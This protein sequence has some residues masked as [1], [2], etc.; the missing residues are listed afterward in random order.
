MPAARL[1]SNLR[2][3]FARSA[4]S[5]AQKTKTTMLPRAHAGLLWKGCIGLEKRD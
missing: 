4:K 3:T 1:S 5:G 2:A